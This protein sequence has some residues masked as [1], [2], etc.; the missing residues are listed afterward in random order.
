MLLSRRLVAKNSFKYQVAAARRFSSEPVREDYKKMIA[1][2][3]KLMKLIDPIVKEHYE[4]C[5][6]PM[7]KPL[8]SLNLPPEITKQLGKLQH[9]P[10]SIE[11]CVETIRKTF[12]LSMNTMNPFFLDKL[13]S[14]S[15]PIGQVAELVVAILNTAVHVY[16]VA[17]VFSVM[18]VELVKIF[19][20]RFGFKE[21]DID[22]TLNPGGTMSNMM[23]LLAARHQHF[24]HVR[25]K[26]W[27]PGD[28]AV[29]FTAT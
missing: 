8:A 23:A 11:Q 19:G 17:P 29:G 9:E 5:G 25:R 22:G 3:E 18:E 2:Y 4:D 13:Y 7:T 15:D 20:K 27:L 6:R 28:N 26:G 14:G 16:H 1:D 21:E 10:Q 12:D 24:P